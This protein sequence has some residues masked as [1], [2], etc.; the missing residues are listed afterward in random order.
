MIQ[1][2][3]KAKWNN[4]EKSEVVLT[5]MNDTT[6]KHIVDDVMREHTS[7]YL[8]FIKDGEVEAFETESERIKREENEQK[9]A[10]KQARDEMLKQGTISQDGKMWFNFESANMFMTA[11]GTL[12]VGETISWYDKDRQKVVLTYDE[13]KAYSKEIR[14]VMQSL[15]GLN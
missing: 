15:Y 10:Q 6:A 14:I 3:K 7:S 8:T 13:A 11:V 9:Q 4:L 5:F 2:I 12:D 1:K